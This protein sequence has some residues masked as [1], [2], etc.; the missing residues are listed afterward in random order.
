MKYRVREILLVST[1]YDAFTLEQESRLSQQLVGQYHMLNLTTI[2][3]ITS[4]PTGEEAISKLKKKK[5]DL[6]ITTMRIGKSTPFQFSKQIKK[7]D[8]DVPVLLLLTIKSDINLVEKSTHSMKYIDQVFLWHGDTKLLLAMIKY[9]E[10][11]KN[12]ER[13]TDIA[14]VRVI[15]L[16]ENSISYYSHYLPLLYTELMHQTQMLISQEVNDVQKYYRMRARPKIILTSSYD[17]AVKLTEKY[18]DY[19][20]CTIT[21][22]SFNYPGNPDEKKRKKLIKQLRNKHD[23]G[24]FL[25]QS[26]NDEDKAFA[27]C[28][29]AYFIHKDSTTL[30]SEFRQFLLTHLGFGDFIFTDENNHYYDQVSSTIEMEQ[31]L[32]EIPIQSVLYHSSQN[33]FSAWLI[34]HGEI[35]V[36]K[37]IEPV[38]NSDFA[39]PEDLRKMLISVF[40][41]VG[42][43]RRK[44]KIVEFDIDSIK[45]CDQIVKLADGSLGG[46]GRGIAFINSLLSTLEMNTKFKNAHISI[47][48]TAIIG[49]D[50]FDY[51]IEHN[52]LVDVIHCNDD[53][54]IKK[55]FLAGKLSPTVIKRLKI[56]LE[57]ITKPLA[58]RSSGLLEDSQSQPFAGIYQTYMIPNNHE[59]FNQRLKGLMNAIKLVFASSFLQMAKSYIASLNYRVVEEKMAVVIQEIVGDQHGDR[60]YPHFAGV[61]QSYNFYPTADVKHEEG[62][63]MIAVGLGQS[64]VEGGKA[65]RFCPHYPNQ[66]YLSLEDMIKYSQTEFYAIDLTQKNFDLKK[67]DHI[68]LSANKISVAESDHTLYHSASVWDAVNQRI[69]EDLSIKGPRI[70]NFANVL[71]YDYFPLCK[72]LIELL[73]VTETA[74]G[75][76]VEIEFAVNLNH[77]TKKGIYPTFYFLQARPLTVQLEEISL[78]D[79]HINKEEL[80]LYTEEGM[81]HGTINDLSDIIYLNPVSFDKTKTVEMMNEIASLNEKMVAQD[82]NYILI[83]PGRWGSRDRFLGIP[84]QWPQISKAKII[85][86]TGLK[87]FDIDPS[88]G[89]H[90]F[91]NLV[92]M[93][94]GYFNVP[95]HSKNDFIDWDWIL[96]QKTIYQ[97]KYFCHIQSQDFFKVSMDGKQGI[98]IIYKTG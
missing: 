94:I 1:F 48:S 34:A 79:E 85:V 29:K 45:S 26:A 91:H 19:L 59:D 11:R 20:L 37:R 92:S 71:K 51:F 9:I 40:Q 75:I 76:P 44:G 46:K 28:L 96:K 74:F 41:E 87:D 78:A 70:I 58:I 50:E 30:L 16:L 83:G 73:D 22:I 15:L 54:V 67:G 43:S 52:R 21:D 80:L 7:I 86:E 33:H 90:F 82:K 64:V 89:T 10:D 25:F 31:K 72:I 69:E 62:V 61:A 49:T 23:L 35:Q 36:A 3:R 2:P 88:Q 6:V 68:T 47:P 97:G 12:L 5:Y 4:V 81:G 84:V 95:Y 24:P 77:D 93:N 42:Q 13:D 66:Q 17:E 65:Y 57:I 8:P 27:E 56:Y 63:A 60:Y 98:A 38:K 39:D 32:A 14:M 18:Q 53:E 55:K